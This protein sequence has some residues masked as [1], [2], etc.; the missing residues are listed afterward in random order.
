MQIIRTVDETKNALN[1]RRRSRQV[2]LVPTMGNLHKGHT[3]M[4]KACQ[5]ESDLTVLSLFV[6]PLL[7]PDS[8]AFAAFP[9]NLN[10]DT[11]HAERLGVDYLFAP[12][13]QE[14]FPRGC[15]DVTRLVLPPLA[16]D[17][18]GTGAPALYAAK[19]TVLLK[20]LNIVQPDLLYVSEKDLLLLVLLQTMLTDLNLDTQMRACPIVRDLDGTAVGSELTRLTEPERE[21]A[22]ILQ[23][24]LKDVAHALANGARNYSGLEQTARVALRGGGFSVK[25]VA[26]RDGAALTAPTPASD[27]LRVLACA[28][29]GSA[30][31]IDNITV[32]L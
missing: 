18:P 6:N 13:D 20:L 23:Q 26:I 21:Q 4:L 12:T 25:Y 3:A 8:A 7:F 1:W 15:A 30:E 31:L 2:G 11:R 27:S 5:D 19:A 24:T 28:Q 29:L 22:P 14:M 17:L 9:R 16:D 32:K 10:D